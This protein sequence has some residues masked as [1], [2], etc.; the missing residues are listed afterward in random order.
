MHEYNYEVVNHGYTL[1][2]GPGPNM[3]P[4]V[5]Y[6][7]ERNDEGKLV[8][9]RNGDPITVGDA[10]HQVRL[11][12]PVANWLKKWAHI[13]VPALMERTDTNQPAV[14]EPWRS[15]LCRYVIEVGHDAIA[16]VDDI[17]VARCAADSVGGNV[18]TADADYELAPR[19]PQ[20]YPC[21]C[22]KESRGRGFIGADAIHSYWKC[23]VCEGLYS[24]PIEPCAICGHP[25]TSAQSNLDEKLICGFCWMESLDMDRVNALK[26]A[27]EYWKNKDEEST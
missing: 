8:L 15:T 18:G 7:F 14:L 4:M 20:I 6:T 9:K 16:I 24:E 3:S 22:E 2:M 17:D 1:V 13:D 25:V 12:G 23:G 27:R 5:R 26:E 19:D 21:R 10:Q 11:R